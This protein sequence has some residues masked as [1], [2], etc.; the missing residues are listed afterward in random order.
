MEFGTLIGGWEKDKRFQLH[1][2]LVN[3][4]GV[5]NT[6]EEATLIGVGAQYLANYEDY[7]KN[8]E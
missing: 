4:Y 5:V 6:E 1:K 2:F 3:R 8:N 7:A